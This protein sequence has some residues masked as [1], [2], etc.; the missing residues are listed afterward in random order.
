MSGSNPKEKNGRAMIW[1]LG[2]VAVLM[3]GATM[4]DRPITIAASDNPA[5]ISTPVTGIVASPRSMQEQRTRSVSLPPPAQSGTQIF[6][7][8]WG[9]PK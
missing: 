4:Q 1:F 2:T 9:V 5:S 7:G 6:Y 8:G 3:V